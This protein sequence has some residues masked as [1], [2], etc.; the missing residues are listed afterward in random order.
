MT[1]KFTVSYN[2]WKRE[3][4]RRHSRIRKSTLL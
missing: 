2:S 4:S 1:H 3:H